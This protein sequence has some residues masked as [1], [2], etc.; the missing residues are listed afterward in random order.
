ML[1]RLPTLCQNNFVPIGIVGKVYSTVYITVTISESF[2]IIDLFF[3]SLSD[4]NSQK[5]KPRDSLMTS[6]LPIILSDEIEMIL[7]LNRFSFCNK[8]EFARKE[9]YSWEFRG[10]RGEIGRL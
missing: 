10:W 6:F 3:I 5:I 2:N 8:A 9:N 1:A 4:S 7:L